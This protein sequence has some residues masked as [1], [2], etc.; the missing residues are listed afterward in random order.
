M[1]DRPILSVFHTVTIDTMLNNK[2]ARFKEKRAR[3]KKRYV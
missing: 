2:T 1:G 3:A